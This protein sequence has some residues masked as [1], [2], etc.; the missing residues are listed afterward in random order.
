MEKFVLPEK[1]FIK[2]TFDNA[3]IVNAWICKERNNS[4]AA[5]LTDTATV[6]SNTKYHSF[7][8]SNYTNGY[9]EL[10]FEQFLEYVINKKPIIQDSTE[11]NKILIK[12]LS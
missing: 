5:F 3:D 8:D 9:T 7:P 1:W 4:N 2:R 12:L 6:L 11:L 10:T